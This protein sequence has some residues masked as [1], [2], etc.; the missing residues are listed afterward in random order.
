MK[1]KK[2]NVKKAT[3]VEEVDWVSGAFL[4]VK[5]KAIEKAGLMDEDFFLYAEE[6]EWCSRLQKAGKLCIFGDIS[7]THLCGEAI[8]NA[9]KT[10]DN[11]YAN[12]FDKKGLQL[13]VSN[14]LHIR[15]QFGVAWFLFQLINF[16]WAVP[17][18]FIGSFFDHLF[19]QQNPFADSKKIKGL[20]SNVAAVWR[21]APAI[22]RNKPFFYKML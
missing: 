1:V 18:Y 2:P 3:A 17:V 5:K 7:L 4:M 11:N 20:A 19:H 15:K 6:V 9:T 13:I 10:D 21:L 8:S 16:T 22:I 12:L 14:H